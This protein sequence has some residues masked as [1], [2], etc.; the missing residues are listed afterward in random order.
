M[1]EQNITTQS[2][3]ESALTDES[4]ESVAG[5]VR[6]LGDPILGPIIC[7]LPT[8]PITG[9]VTTPILLDSTDTIA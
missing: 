9:P 2:A 4:L 3:D 6:S 5:G 1:S 8:D 7:P